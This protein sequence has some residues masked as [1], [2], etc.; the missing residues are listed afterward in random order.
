MV[1]KHTPE[2]LAKMS[3]FQQ[4]KHKGEDNTF[5]GKKHTM[6]TKQKVSASNTKLTKSMREEIIYKRNILGEKIKNLA[7]EYNVSRATIYNVLKGKY[8]Y[9]SV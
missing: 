9:L 5:Y 2:S 3:A 1:K 7:L 8:A 4:G 6:E